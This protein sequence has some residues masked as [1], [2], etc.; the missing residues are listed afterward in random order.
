MM[1]SAARDNAA[2]AQDECRKSQRASFAQLFAM[3]MGV[4]IGLSASLSGAHAQG[5]GTIPLQSF[6]NS[7]P[8]QGDSIRFCVDDFSVGAAFDRSVAEAISEALLVKAEFRPAPA[9]FPLDGT[10]YLDELQLVMSKEC[11]VLVGI[12]LT[13]GMA[14]SPFPD[15]ATVTR[16]YAQVPFVVVVTDASYKSIGD[17]PGGKFMG[18]MIGSLG[19][20]AAVTF[21]Q[22]RPQDQRLRYLPY[23]D[24]NLML[25]RLLDGSIAGMIIWQ[26]QLNQITKGDLAGPGLKI[27]SFAP[28]KPVLTGVGNLVSSRE[29]YLRASIDQA[30]GQLVADGTIAKL[31]KKHG[32]EGVA[33]P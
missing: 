13:P 19:I 32:Y 25:K 26:P 24:P 7:R 20:G 5:A 33:G 28:M 10:G 29:S 30:I 15:W 27:A 12:S 3:M 18:G 8:L 1:I 23:G 31:M 2:L 22:Q 16:S 9:G 17:I 14:E 11:E 4:L 21:N 6:S